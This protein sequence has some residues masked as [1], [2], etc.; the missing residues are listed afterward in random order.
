[1]V[2]S[3]PIAVESEPLLMLTPV[4]QP[5]VPVA[6]QTGLTPVFK[7]FARYLGHA[8]LANCALATSGK[9]RIARSN[10]C[11]IREAYNNALLKLKPL[12]GLNV[13]R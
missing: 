5:T 7:A 6:P 3:A 12:I 8:E 9:S 2:P 13:V 1:M 10:T 4:D 11:R